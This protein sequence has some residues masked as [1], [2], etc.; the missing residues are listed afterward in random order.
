MSFFIFKVKHYIS[1]SFTLPLN[2]LS[3]NNY[4]ST[5]LM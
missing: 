1:I 5:L 2:P 4:S 3:K